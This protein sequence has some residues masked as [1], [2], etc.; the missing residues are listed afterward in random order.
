MFDPR[1]N[2][3]ELFKQSTY[4]NDLGT[5]YYLTVTDDDG[6]NVNIPVYMAEDAR[7]KP[8]PLVSL[9]LSYSLQMPADIGAN[10]YA[11]TAIIDANIFLPFKAEKWTAHTIINSIADQIESTIQA[12]Q[13]TTTGCDFVE[14][15]AMRDLTGLE[16]NKVLRWLVEIR[17]IVNE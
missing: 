9:G 11:N 6:A 5:F 17:A 8:M 12:A 13:N 4:D 14:C 16:K 2:I 1:S 3:R 10:I 15:S 7:D